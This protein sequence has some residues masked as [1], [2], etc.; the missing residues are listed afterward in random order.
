MQLESS[1]STL[2]PIDEVE[3]V[4]RQKIAMQFYRTCVSTDLCGNDSQIRSTIKP[5]QHQRL[6]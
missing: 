2:L 3:K 6:L 4:Q 1:A 5:N